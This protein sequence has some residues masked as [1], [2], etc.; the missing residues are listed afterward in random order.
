MVRVTILLVGP[1]REK[2]MQAF[3]P[4][5][6]RGTLSLQKPP[7]ARDVKVFPEMTS[8]SHCRIDRS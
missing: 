1:A 4:I 6:P 7:H 5:G 8:Q 2:G 3:S